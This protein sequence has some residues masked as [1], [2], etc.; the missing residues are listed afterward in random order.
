MSAFETMCRIGG[1]M[2]RSGAAPGMEAQ[3]ASV[4]GMR[5]LGMWLHVESESEAPKGDRVGVRDV[6]NELATHEACTVL[7]FV[8]RTVSVLD[9]D[10][11]GCAMCVDRHARAAL[12]RGVSWVQGSKRLEK[13]I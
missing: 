11:C 13:K 4:C 7:S 10:S 3:G 12:G 2:D 6:T 1:D 5:K 8:N 9:L